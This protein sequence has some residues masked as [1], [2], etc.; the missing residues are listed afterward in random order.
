MFIVTTSAQDKIQIFR[1]WLAENI[2]KIN[3][4]WWGD[5][6]LIQQLKN[7]KSKT[8]LKWMR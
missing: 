1:K 8:A 7:C 4:T 2:T 6:V 5:R 3:K